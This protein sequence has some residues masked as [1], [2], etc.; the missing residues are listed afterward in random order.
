MNHDQLVAA[1]LKI[2]GAQYESKVKS[3][4]DDIY[5]KNLLAMNGNDPTA[6]A[7]AIKVYTPA[8]SGDTWQVSQWLNSDG[9]VSNTRGPN[10]TGYIDKSGIPQALDSALQPSGTQNYSGVTSVN[11]YDFPYYDEGGTRI[12]DY[13]NPLGRT[14]DTGITPYQQ[15]ELANWKTEFDAQQQQNASS[16]A[17]QQNAQVLDQLNLTNSRRDQWV[18]T[19]NAL[20]NAQAVARDSDA[21]A[22]AQAESTYNNVLSSQTGPSDWINYWKVKQNPP[23]SIGYG[24]NQFATDSTRQ[25]FASNAEEA[26]RLGLSQWISPEALSQYWRE[27]NVST[28]RQMV[29]DTGTEQKRPETD[30]EMT[31]RMYTVP[32]RSL[33]INGAPAGTFQSY[34]DDPN[35]NAWIEDY[36]RRQKQAQRLAVSASATDPYAAPN[37]TLLPS[38]EELELWRSQN[39]RAQASVGPQ[40]PQWATQ[41]NTP[42]QNVDVTGHGGIQNQV[43]MNKLRTWNVNPVSAQ[44]WNALAP[45][46]QSGLRGL[47]EATG[48]P[49]DDYVAN[50]QNTWAKP[51]YAVARKRTAVY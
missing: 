5:L 23:R 35:E 33:Q 44:T 19:Q 29:W 1:I 40:T 20:S 24:A 8:E 32:V 18:N 9:T 45:S 16:L 43:D 37:N 13:N 50:A 27:H 49:W 34:S 51:G 22:Q 17:L 28:E 31:Y 42:T 10:T 48:T 41:F 47:V 21:R 2:I 7:A 30:A 36:V 26:A 25:P 3:I 39:P 14:E 6:M 11:G 15:Q 4:T 12:I 38:Q 46:E